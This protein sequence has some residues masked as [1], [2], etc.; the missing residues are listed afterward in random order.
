MR[1]SGPDEIFGLLG[2][3]DEI[4]CGHQ[5]PYLHLPI[6][7]LQLGSEGMVP[8]RPTQRSASPLAQLI[9]GVLV[10]KL[11]AQ[12]VI[13]ILRYAVWRSCSFGG[14]SLA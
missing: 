6:R 10:N 4:M 11:G 13:Y 2:S 14:A 3:R 7:D 5:R 1:T 9:H 12:Q 8:A